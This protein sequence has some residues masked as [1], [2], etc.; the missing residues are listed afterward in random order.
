MRLDPIA[1]PQLDR[2]LQVLNT[3][4]EQRVA[5]EQSRLVERRTRPI[6]PSDCLK[7]DA[8][9]E[10]PSSA[11]FVVARQLGSPQER[12]GG[13]RMRAPVASFS[14]RPLEQVG[15]LVVQPLPQRQRDARR[16]GPVSRTP[17]PRPGARD[18]VRCSRSVIDRRANERV[19]PRE[20]SAGRLDQRR[21]F[22]GLERCRVDARGGECAEHRVELGRVTRSSEEQR[23]DGRRRERIDSAPERPSQTGPCRQQFGQRLVARELSGRQLDRDLRERERIP[24]CLTNDP[25]GDRRRRVARTDLEQ[26]VRGVWVEPAD[27]EQRE[28]FDARRARFPRA[29][30]E[31]RRDPLG[32]EPA[33][34]EDERLRRRP[35]EPVRVVQNEDERCVGGSRPQQAQR[36]GGNGEAVAGHRW[37]ER[38]RA[39]QRRCLRL[40]ESDRAVEDRPQ[41]L[42]ERTERELGFGL[43]A[44]RGE[45]TH[46]GRAPRRILE[47]RA[48][49]DSRLPPDHEHAA[50]PGP[51]LVQQV[52]DPAA[53]GRPAQQHPSILGSDGELY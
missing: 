52:G 49:A 33:R 5:G 31:Q 17:P 29:D 42:V 26:R 37:P 27:D 20:A 51:R 28:A 3:R 19:P 14:G 43:H 2:S 8:R 44:P 45:H 41:Q 7:R 50:T 13:C 15:H 21:P 1:A 36:S 18:A 30:G 22:C 6:E 23:L 24:L 11:T 25:I 48:L 40:G 38:E 12:V 46:P 35:V 32:S 53:L 34:C 10:Q 47:Q 39:R 9:L 16:A 4:L